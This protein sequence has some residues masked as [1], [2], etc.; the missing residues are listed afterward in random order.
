MGIQ[1]ATYDATTLEAFA[2][3]LQGYADSVQALAIAVRQL[4]AGVIRPDH[5]QKK[6]NGMALV[7]KWIREATLLAKTELARVA[8]ESADP[9]HE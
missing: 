4:P 8:M 3:E 1:K 9:G 2:S 7:S 5:E 6:H